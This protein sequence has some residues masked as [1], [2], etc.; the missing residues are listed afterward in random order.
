MGDTVVITRR[1]QVWHE[2]LDEAV[3]NV[4]PGDVLLVVQVG[5][6]RR[7]KRLNPTLY[8]KVVTPAGSVGWLHFD[9]CE[10]LYNCA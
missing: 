8:G 7:P 5:H 2:D 3:C 10:A 6:E 1:C 4:S 9:N